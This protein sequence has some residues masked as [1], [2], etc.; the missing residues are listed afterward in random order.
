MPPGTPTKAIRHA[1]GITR[2]VVGGEHETQLALANL[3][4]IAIHVWGS[5]ASAPRQPDWVC[6]DLD[7]G[8]G[9]ALGGPRGAAGP[10][11]ARSA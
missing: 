11:G 1:N 3:G 2:Y 8:T 5:R 9:D 10:G 7:P 4:C 6:F